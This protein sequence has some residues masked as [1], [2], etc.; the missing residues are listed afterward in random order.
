M[1][2]G[3]RG[4]LTGEESGSESWVIE[5]DD[6]SVEEDLLGGGHAAIAEDRVEAGCDRVLDRQS[7]LAEFTWK[8]IVDFWRRMPD[9]FLYYC[10]WSADDRTDFLRRRRTNRSSLSSARTTHQLDVLRKRERMISRYHRE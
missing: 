8:R 7:V 9:V 5:F 1:V 2:C 4:E 3:E 6:E 10:S